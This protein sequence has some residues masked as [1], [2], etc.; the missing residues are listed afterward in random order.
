MRICESALAIAF[1]H[2]IYLGVYVL[3]LSVLGVFLTIGAQ[4]GSTQASGFASTE[5]QEDSYASAHASVAVIDRDGSELSAELSAHLEETQEL[6][7]VADDSFAMQ[8]ALATGLV[9]AIVIV[10]EGYEA[11]LFA[12][13]RAGE[14]L[15]SLQIAYGTDTQAAALLDAQVARWTALTAASAALEP[16]SSAADVADAVRHASAAHAD[17]SVERAAAATETARP[18]Q[19]YLSF[20]S[21][22]ITCSVVVCAGLV[23][24]TMNEEQLRAR[25]FAAPVRPRRL[26]MNTLA[27][28]V[29]LV[30]AVWGVTS[31][32]GLVASGALTSS[33]GIPPAGIVLALLAMLV[34][35]LV[36]LAMAFVLAQARFGEDALNAL[37]NIGGMLM[38]FLGGAW[39]PLSLL[40]DS[41][42]AAAHFV[43]TFWTND[44]IA[45]VLG[46]PALTAEVLARYA[47]G[48]GVTALFAVAITCVGLALTRHRA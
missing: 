30:V 21:Y 3:F 5:Q 15:P 37:G 14:E 6:V 8:D 7:D 32:V 1:R 36:P 33:A 40:G 26:G 9:E 43:P 31:A 35:A 16:S 18:L 46:T 27:A 45:A 23:F 42:R 11:E 39:V 47:C 34:F 13:A 41:V 28:C 44:A 4:P 38:S 2:P 17:I 10:P 25:I 24:S 12:C 20:T 29:V 48:V 19:A 22:S